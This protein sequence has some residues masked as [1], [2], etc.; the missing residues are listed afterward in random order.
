MK[1]I[2]V[3]VITSKF[4][5]GKT[6]NPIGIYTAVSG[7][8]T[9]QGHLSDIHPKPLCSSTE[10]RKTVLTSR[11]DGTLEYSG[12][13]VH[14]YYYYNM[15]VSRKILHRRVT[16]YRTTSMRTTSFEKINVKVQ[17][18]AIGQCHKITRTYI[19]FSVS[20]SCNT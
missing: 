15:P 2:I 16:I 10:T 8:F 19:V 7:Y 17:S 20:L 11:Y 4:V 3:I 6:F 13:M 12:I 9:R 5:H 18:T 1:V 14:Y